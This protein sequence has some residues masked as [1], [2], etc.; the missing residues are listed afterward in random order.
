MS[1]CDFPRPP[2]QSVT[3]C[4]MTSSDFRLSRWN[5]HTSDFNLYG[6]FMPFYSRHL[7]RLEL[8][9]SCSQDNIAEKACCG[10]PCKCSGERGDR[11][12]IGSIGPKVWWLCP[13]LTLRPG[14]RSPLL[15]WLGDVS[16]VTAWG[17]RKAEKGCSQVADLRSKHRFPSPYSW[18]EGLF[19]N[20]LVL[21]FMKEC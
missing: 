20:T 4:H 12:P 11:G 13:F 16:T 18:R 5:P 3:E 7:L 17:W 6:I 10:V 1:T 19:L 21:H 2:S 9:F 15:P 8:V 14:F